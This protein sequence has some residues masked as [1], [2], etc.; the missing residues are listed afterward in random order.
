MV[1]FIVLLCL[2]ALILVKHHSSEHGF[3]G[4]IYFGKA[5]ETSQLPEVGNRGFKASL[6]IGYDGQFYAQLALRPALADDDIIEALDNPAYRAR[7]I[8]LPLLA[9]VLGGGQPALTLQVYALLNVVFWLILLFVIDRHVGLHL[10][11][12][13]LLF[14]VLLWSTGT[15]ASIERSL[16]DFPAVVLG[17]LALLSGRKW[18]I[19]SLLFGVSGLCKETSVLSFAAAPWRSKPER[20]QARRLAT[21]AAMTLLP[22]AI[23]VSYIHFRIPADLV[24]GSNN[25]AL[26]FV[27]LAHKLSDTV[28]ALKTSWDSAG[29]GSR[30]ASLFELIAPM[31][32][33]I[34]ATYLLVK[35][36][37]DSRQWLFGIAFA[38]LLFVLGGNVWADQ[39][40]Y[41]RALL[42]LTFSFNLLIHQQECRGKF[43]AWY[44]LGNVGMFWRAIA[45]LTG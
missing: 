10:P 26:P 44:T 34:Q 19:S 9:Y 7:R 2:P 27:G 11:R 18:F 31:S 42:P 17:V 29:P 1:F 32:L 15:L 43:L 35:P 20:V 13:G 36:Q 25:F 45:Y 40:A 33:L 6:P 41:C 38:I 24:M 23:W 3:L 22:I 37:V 14:I 39:Y 30:M 12:N 5:F 28:L 4:L 21:V 8:G 16:A